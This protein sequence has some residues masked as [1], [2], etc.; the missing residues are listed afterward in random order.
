M[1]V[2][3]YVCQFVVYGCVDMVSSF[4]FY[5]GLSEFVYTCLDTR[6]CV[7]V[8]CCVLCVYVYIWVYQ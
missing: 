6:L 5:M 7:C 8:V 1:S 4:Q 3:V 2:C